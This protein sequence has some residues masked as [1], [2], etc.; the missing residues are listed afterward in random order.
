MGFSCGLVVSSFAFFSGGAFL[1]VTACLQSSSSSVAMTTVQALALQTKYRPMLNHK[2][3]I[4]LASLAALW[5]CVMQPYGLSSGTPYVCAPQTMASRLGVNALTPLG[6][7]ANHGLFAP[8][9]AFAA[10]GLNYEL[11]FKPG[12]VLLG[13][14]RAERDVRT[15]SVSASKRGKGISPYESRASRS[16]LL[17]LNFHG[18]RANVQ[19]RGLSPAASQ[20]HYFLGNKSKDWQTGLPNFQR[21][22]Y[23]TIYPGIDLFFYGNDGQLEYDFVVAPGADA[24]AIQMQVSGVEQI[25]A[26]ANG[27]VLLATVVGELRQHKPLAY[28]MTASGKR[29]IQSRFVVN[30]DM[31]SFALGEYDPCLPLVIDPVLSYASLLGGA[32]AEAAEAIAVDSL[33]YLYVTGWTHY[34]TG[35]SDN[36]PQT[37]SSVLSARHTTA[38]AGNYLFVAKLNPTAT[39][40]IYSAIIGGTQGVVNDTG[41]RVLDNVGSDI[42]VD[43]AGNVYVT[44]RTQSLNFPT[45][46]GALQT[47]GRPRKDTFEAFALKLN[48]AGNELVYSTLLGQG[49]AEARGLALDGSGNVWVTGF[50]DNAAFP[51]TANAWQ[52]TKRNAAATSAFV[53]QL[54]ASGSELLYST[55]L[56]SGGG[57]V[58]LDIAADEAGNAYA[59]GWTLSSCAA[60]GGNPFPTTSEA[61]QRDTG[62]GCVNGRPTFYSYL[63]KFAAF[64]AVEY[65]TLLGGSQASAV[66][67]DAAGNAY[68][69]GRLASGLP[70]PIVNAWQPRVLDGSLQAGFLAKFN[71]R[72][73][74]LDYS[75]Y[76]T[77]SV[78]AQDAGLDVAVDAAGQAYLTGA[79]SSS[80]FVTTQQD[81]PFQTKSG[82]FV[83]KLNASGAALDYSVIFGGLGTTGY[84]LAVDAAGNAWVAGANTSDSFPATANAFQRASTGAADAFIAK[85]GDAP[86]PR[87][88]THLSAA[89]YAIT[90]AAESIV[91]AFGAD[92]AVASGSARSL[93]LPI[94]LAG[95]SVTIRDS[96]GATFAA[97]LFFV[98]P[99]QVNYLV[100]RG[101]ATGQAT[102]TITNG[103]G[104]ITTG[105]LQVDPIAPGIFT[106]NANGSGVP[107]AVWLCLRADG[108]QSFQPVARYDETTRR[109]VSVPLDA[110]GV[111]PQSF[112]LLFGTGWRGRTDLQGVA[113]R[114]DQEATAVSYAGIQDDLVGLDQINVELPRALCGRGE[115]N[116]TLTVDGRMANPVKLAFK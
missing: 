23:E 44:G 30:G 79:V 73:S 5:L 27:D 36:F 45:T 106:A 52:R 82:A 69:T 59:T 39:K 55:F 24:L 103:N 77:G 31:L 116:L 102:V 97:P 43:A 105:L 18:A 10:H 28:Q 88:A 83:I 9:I 107:A 74:A 86:L 20:T 111:C 56:S 46:T 62:A 76:V 12:A 42:S 22:A 95:T 37:P 110:C 66:A 40:L 109:M 35:A 92:L 115:T 93:P 113:V 78:G 81:G 48:A 114:I 8:D 64:G 50:T 17:S 68:V 6:F 51:T 15:V 80:A 57:E 3:K 108:T 14:A 85:L 21:L 99:E 65:S 87:V 89:S 75:T 26:L 38:D 2:P 16:A 96:R 98:A 58:G 101:C 13:A 90:S 72:G 11:F 7:V 49:S 61:F 4:P 33:G 32:R 104:L 100:P 94:T 19:P 41:Q 70:F 1:H 29:I 34:L 112:L 54:N 67:V 53:S 63:T 60:G 71:R 47:L 25:R 91:A 84:G